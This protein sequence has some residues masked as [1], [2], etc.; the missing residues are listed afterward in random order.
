MKKFVTICLATMLA[1]LALP[2]MALANEQPIRVATHNAI[3]G[4]EGQP[5]AM[6]RRYAIFP[7]VQ[8]MIIN[9][10]VFVPL[11]GLPLFDE[12][13]WFPGC[14]EVN[15]SPFALT[16]FYPG[17][18]MFAAYIIKPGGYTVTSLA[19][20]WTCCF[21]STLNHALNNTN[22]LRFLLLRAGDCPYVRISSSDS[23]VAPQI[24]DGRMMVPLRMLESM[25]MSTVT[26][27]SNTR[28]ALITYFAS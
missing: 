23:I 9:D 8:P 14:T 16:V 25:G 20:D 12:V 19:S 28:T 3:T 26:W 18:S 15:V 5:Y 24:I 2:T 11:R 22:D 17:G 10:R 13:R 7:D 1:I 21:A 6:E 4:A 27:D